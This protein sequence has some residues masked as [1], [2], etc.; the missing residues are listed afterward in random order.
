MGL[1]KQTISGISQQ[2]PSAVLKPQWPQE[3]CLDQRF[4]I[5]YGLWLHSRDSSAPMA[6]C[7]LINFA[8][9]INQP[10]ATS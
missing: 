3:Q 5:F 9:N 2:L 7:S 8:F 4:S 6:H 10:F 1:K